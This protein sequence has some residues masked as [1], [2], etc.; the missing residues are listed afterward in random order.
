MIYRDLNESF[1]G[2]ADNS[3]R[4]LMPDNFTEFEKLFLERK[5][6]YLKNIEMAVYNESPEKCAEL[7][8]ENIDYAIGN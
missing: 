2:M 8:N 5:P 6:I 7:I 3:G 4:P 1:S